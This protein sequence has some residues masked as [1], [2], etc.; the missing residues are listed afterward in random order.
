MIEQSILDN[1]ALIAVFK[2]EFDKLIGKDQIRNLAF[3]CD[4]EEDTQF[5]NDFVV[6]DYHDYSNIIQIT[7]LVKKQIVCGITVDVVEVESILENVVPISEVEELQQLTERIKKYTVASESI[8]D[9]YKTC[10]SS[11]LKSLS[12]EF[13]VFV[14]DTKTAT[15]GL[16]SR[17][18]GFITEHAVDYDGYPVLT[19]NVFLNQNPFNEINFKTID[20]YRNYALDIINQEQD[21]ESKQQQLVTLDRFIDIKLGF[22]NGVV[23]SYETVNNKK[24]EEYLNQLWIDSNIHSSD[25]IRGKTPN[26]F[27]PDYVFNN[28][29]VRYNNIFVVGSDSYNEE[30]MRKAFKAI[31]IDSSEYEKAFK[32]N[33]EYK[34]L[35]N[36]FDL[37]KALSR[38]TTLQFKQIQLART[39]SKIK[40]LEES[41]KD[42]L[43]KLNDFSIKY[44]KTLRD[45]EV[46]NIDLLA[47][48]SADS[49][50]RDRDLENLLQ[51]VREVD[52]FST[53][54]ID[55]IS[56]AFVIE[57]KDVLMEGNNDNYGKYYKL[58]EYMYA[59]CDFKSNQLYCGFFIDD[60]RVRKGYGGVITAHPHAIYTDRISVDYIKVPHQNNKQLTLR[61]F[62]F[63]N[64]DNLISKNLSA[65]NISVIADLFITFIKSY[66]AADAAGE[67]FNKWEVC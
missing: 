31:Q 17:N 9:L 28:I 12:E 7:K 41:Q 51:L 18:L 11:F 52:Y 5:L 34:N 36:T 53:Y 56:H 13:K 47:Y 30:D 39:T 24:N 8:V 67:Y 66:N 6:F 19:I 43:D 27:D 62:C 55:P 2:S 22:V 37:N 40:T 1:L 57:F 16:N 49:V 60:P 65:Y 58:P 38:Q 54:W 59:V 35:L 21:E 23:V 25:L 3:S 63:G 10:K 48:K 33:L 20:Q 14:N 15:Y 44:S 4:T 50:L 45:L 61:R 29:V 26:S 46:I 32:S 64:Y 42:L